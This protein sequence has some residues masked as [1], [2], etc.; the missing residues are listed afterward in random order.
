MTVQ[1]TEG[2]RDRGRTLLSAQLCVSGLHCLGVPGLCPSRHNPQC[3]S[4]HTLQSPSLS[5]AFLSSALLKPAECVQV[6][7]ASQAALADP[8]R[9]QALLGC[10]DGVD[11]AGLAARVPRAFWRQGILS[12]QQ[13][14]NLPNTATSDAFKPKSDA[15]ISG[16]H[17]QGEAIFLPACAILHYS[18]SY[19]EG[20]PLFADK[21]RLVC[22]CLFSDHQA[23]P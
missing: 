4:T 8:S 16:A 11:I 22:T 9:Q 12:A 21:A 18:N 7:L 10:K 1:G 14:A 17:A 5:K 6:D 23:A 20:L 13:Q 15:P 2:R 3:T 19:F